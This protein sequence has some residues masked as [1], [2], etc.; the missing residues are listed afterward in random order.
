MKKR[1]ISILLC[2]TIAATLFTACN[3]KTG[4]DEPA[5]DIVSES[6]TTE[7]LSGTE[8]VASIE[9]V[10]ENEN[11]LAW[12]KQN[13]MNFRSDADIITD[14]AIPVMPGNPTIDTALDTYMEWHV[15]DFEVDYCQFSEC[16]NNEISAGMSKFFTL[17][18]TKELAESFDNGPKSD[19]FLIFENHSEETITV[20]QAIENK[21]FV[22]SYS[23]DYDKYDFGE[24]TM[25]INLGYSEE[26][27]SDMTVVNDYLIK[28]YGAPNFCGVGQNF[29]YATLE[30]FVANENHHQMYDLGWIG[31]E[32]GVFTTIRLDEINS[33][34]GSQVLKIDG[35][36]VIPVEMLQYTDE[37]STMP[38]T[39]DSTVYNSNL[40]K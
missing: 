22:I 16:L 32:Y 19:V 8:E 35:I 12:L 15:V 5:S 18:E 29:D 23:N 27:K 36:K 13:Y 33:Y 39:T 21:W 4:S 37:F 2:T 38:Y 9:E 25:Y 24:S 30:E 10:D 11:N 6:E 17:K 31:D 14:S 7:E 26:K 1:I 20:K 34:D 28:Y 3:S 40:I